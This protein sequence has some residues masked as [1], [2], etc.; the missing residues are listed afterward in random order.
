MKPGAPLI[1]AHH[2]FP[3]ADGAKTRWLERY[4]AFAVAAGGIPAADARNAV[5]AIGSRLPVIAPEH[6]VALLQQAG[7]DNVELFY[8][9]FTFK[10]W[11]AYKRS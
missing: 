11:V 2:S 3:L 6:D 8:A 5:T 10:G 1:V 4:A 9:A 7:F